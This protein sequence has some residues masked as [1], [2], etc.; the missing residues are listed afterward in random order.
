MKKELS[1]PESHICSEMISGVLAT[2][3]KA[4]EI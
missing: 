1:G 4:K 2:L 3:K